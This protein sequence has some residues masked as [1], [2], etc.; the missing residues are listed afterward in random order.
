MNIQLTV[1]IVFSEKDQLSPGNTA[2]SLSWYGYSILHTQ[3][4]F[5]SKNSRYL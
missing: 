1:M 5:S 3:Q 2:E 4:H